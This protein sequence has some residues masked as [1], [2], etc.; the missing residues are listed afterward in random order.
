MSVGASGCAGP[1]LSAVGDDNDEEREQG[2]QCQTK[3]HAAIL[4]APSNGIKAIYSP[5]C[6]RGEGSWLLRIA[7]RST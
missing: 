7:R 5:G 2:N 6:S 1:L 3:L 4:G